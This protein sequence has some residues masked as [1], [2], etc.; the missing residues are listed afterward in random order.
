MTAVTYALKVQVDYVTLLSP[1]TRRG[2]LK[3]N[4]KLATDCRRSTEDSLVAAAAKHRS[5]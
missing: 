2:T 4:L 3:K 5:K 1:G